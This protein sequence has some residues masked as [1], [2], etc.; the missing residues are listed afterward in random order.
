[1]VGHDSAD[2]DANLYLLSEPINTDS[3]E[4]LWIVSV[5]RISHPAKVDRPVT[6]LGRELTHIY[7]RKLLDALGTLDD[8]VQDE[9]SQEPVELDIRPTDQSS[10]NPA[11]FPSRSSL[12]TTDTNVPRQ[13]IWGVDGIDEPPELPLSRIQVRRVCRQLAQD[14]TFELL[15]HAAAQHAVTVPALAVRFDRSTDT[16]SAQC[17]DLE[18]AG[19]LKQCADDPETYLPVDINLQLTL[20]SIVFTLDSPTRM[21]SNVMSRYGPDCME[22][23][24][25]LWPQIKRGDLSYHEASARLNM[26]H[27]DFLTVLLA[28]GFLE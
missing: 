10:M 13:H 16:I 15:R 12:S 4:S 8:T 2:P 17:R 26:P 14:D 3:P 24:R 23:I 27:G 22:N 21:R 6:A 11:A 7:R 19:L 18:R 28:L 25:T 20:E 1:M 9:W 5:S